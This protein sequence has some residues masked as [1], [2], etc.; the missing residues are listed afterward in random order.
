MEEEI[1]QSLIEITNH[2]YDRAKERLSLNK[3]TF[4]KL[5]ESAYLKGIKHSDTKGSLCKYI[6]KIWFSYKSADNVRIYGQNVFLFRGN[7]LITVYQLPNDLRKHL[8]YCK[9]EK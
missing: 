5:A 6:T 7:L 8:R 1:I 4:L 2:A 3:K 9:T